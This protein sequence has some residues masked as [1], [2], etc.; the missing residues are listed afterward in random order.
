MMTKPTA[1]K[2]S[3]ITEKIIGCAMKVHGKMRSGYVEAVYQKCLSIEFEKSG[4][5][6]QMEVDHPIYYEGIIVGRRRVDF[7]IDDKIVVELKALSE[8][9]NAHIA[10]ALNYL[11]TH[12]LEI[13]L[14][15][16]FG[17]KSLQFKRLINERK[18]LSSQQ[19]NPINPTNL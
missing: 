8:F 15:I 9:T 7:L 14:L 4:L 19:K 12:Q 2:Y 18:L 11:E 10:Q 13:G 6:F 1:L 17:A 3:D 5:H 16:N